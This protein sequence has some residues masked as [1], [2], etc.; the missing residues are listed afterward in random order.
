M[1][2]AERKAMNRTQ[3]FIANTP[4]YTAF[5]L[6]FNVSIHIIVFI[7]S[8]DVSQY[9]FNPYKIVYDAEYYR[10]FTSAFLHGGIMHIA[11]N[12]M[13]LVALGGVLEPGYG[14]LRFIWITWVAII[15]AGFNY[16]LLAW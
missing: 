11:M 12:M 14:T 5:L 1:I 10:I 15:L 9:T 3:E 13:S 16:I 4:I 6:I 2:T 8:I 7:L